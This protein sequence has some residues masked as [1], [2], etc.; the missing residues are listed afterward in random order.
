VIRTG[1][2]YLWKEW[3]DHRG[4]A[5][6]CLVA[7]PVVLLVAGLALPPDV[8]GD[9][10][11]A[12]VAA[13]AGLG[14]AAMAVA[15]DLVP[16]EE[17][18][19]TLA[20]LRRTPAGLGAALFGKGAFLL[21]ALAALPLWALCSAW[22]A[23]AV[24]AAPS[25]ALDRTVTEWGPAAFCL[26]L[27]VFVVATWL[28]RGSLALPA[29]ALA[30]ALLLLPVA[31]VFLANPGMEANP[32]ALAV[33]RWILTLGA[34]LAAWLC[35]A[36]GRRFGRGAWASA[37]RGLALLGVLF[38][39]AW[40]Y[41]AIE[42]HEFR[43]FD[44]RDERLV[45]ASGYLGTGGRYVF[46][47]AS[48]GYRANHTVIF[49]LQTGRCRVEGR[50]FDEWLPVGELAGSP[51]QRQRT[52]ALPVVARYEYGTKEDVRSPGGFLRHR[53]AWMHYYD[54]RTAEVLKRGWSDMRFDEVE[55]LHPRGAG[56]PAWR[57]EGGGLRLDDGRVLKVDQG[58]LVAVDG[59][60]GVRQPLDVAAQNWGP[61]ARLPDGGLLVQVWDAGWRSV[62][63]LSADLAVTPVIPW[64]DHFVPVAVE[65]DGA[66]LA[67]WKRRYLAR[68][69][70]GN[71]AP[72]ILFPR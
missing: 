68:F 26:A 16:G 17:R 48:L 5:V 40:G 12:T 58:T 24:F 72:E 28:P 25:L 63:R 44:A 42:Q 27:W 65:E 60:S 1:L 64:G 9:P 36:R 14:V 51:S 50:P 4:L 47:N 11:F 18:R 10:L 30:F 59:D 19:G 62:V 20:F 15:S 22:L 2:A 37:W 29:T 54:G 21:L 66:L 57:F 55:R 35:F 8:V 34:A 41:A 69:R 52:G 39:P 38:L 6:G 46:A 71:P 32:R 45:L 7:F 3:R 67:F 53:K 13:A 61:L 43:Y 31:L 49:D 33:F 23:Q 56:A 70:P